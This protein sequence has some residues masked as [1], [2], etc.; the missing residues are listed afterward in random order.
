MMPEETA[1]AADDLR[2][3]S[4]LPWAY[5]T[6]LCWQNS[7]DDPYQRLAAAA[8]DVVAFSHANAGRTGVVADK[9]QSFNAWWR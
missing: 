5:R 2:A 4:V 9:T 8:K 1:Q 3:R 6:L 7:W